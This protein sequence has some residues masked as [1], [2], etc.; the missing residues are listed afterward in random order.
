MNRFSY[1]R[2]E[3]LADAISHLRG[4]PA[5]AIIAGGTNLVDLM[6]YEVERPAELVDVTRL[7]ARAP[8]D[9]SRAVSGGGRHTAV[10]DRQADR[11]RRTPC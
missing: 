11:V 6:K 4:N 9:R 3:T 2:A 1:H 8:R 10:L 5:A 7:D